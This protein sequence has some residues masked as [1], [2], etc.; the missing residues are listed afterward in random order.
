MSNPEQNEDKLEHYKIILNNKVKNIEKK[1]KDIREKIGIEII[2]SSQYGA[3]EAICDTYGMVINKSTMSDIKVGIQYQKNYE[4][5]LY[6]L[7]E[8]NE[9]DLNIWLYNHSELVKN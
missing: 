6:A 4:D 8:L 3:L 5:T 9:Y 7:K 2:D 1:L